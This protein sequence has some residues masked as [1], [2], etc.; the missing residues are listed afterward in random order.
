MIVIN[1]LVDFKMNKKTAVAGKGEKVLS[2]RAAAINKS[3]ND[4]NSKK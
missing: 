4:K 1:K 2:G 3:K